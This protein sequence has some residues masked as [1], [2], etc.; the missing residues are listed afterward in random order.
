[1]HIRIYYIKFQKIKVQ[2]K[3]APTAYIVSTDSLHRLIHD[4]SHH[5]QH[6]TA[7]VPRLQ[8]IHS[9]AQHN[10]PHRSHLAALLYIYQNSMQVAADILSMYKVR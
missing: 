2:T 1:M 9:N 5:H 4:G 10:L 3:L 7:V 6:A 8:I